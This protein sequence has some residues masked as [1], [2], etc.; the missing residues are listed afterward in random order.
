VNSESTQPLS[1]PEHPR[2]SH[3]SGYV[4]DAYL[5]ELAHQTPGLDLELW[6]EDRKDSLLPTQGESDQ[7]AAASHGFHSTPSFLIEPTASRRPTRILDLVCGSSVLSV[8]IIDLLN[9]LDVRFYK[10]GGRFINGL[11][12]P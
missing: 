11:T 8:V 5:Q 12:C 7:R 4:T 1:E 9:T 3:R 10:S 2:G 6:G